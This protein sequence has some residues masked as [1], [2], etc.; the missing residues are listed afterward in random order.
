MDIV[1]LEPDANG[2]LDEAALAA[3]LEGLG[4]AALDDY[5]FEVKTTGDFAFLPN[6]FGMWMARPLA[7]NGP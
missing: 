5:T 6:I 3:A 1:N 2:N 4:I 7:F